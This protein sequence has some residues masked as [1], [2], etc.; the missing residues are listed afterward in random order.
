[1]KGAASRSPNCIKNTKK[2][3]MWTAGICSVAKIMR[4]TASPPKISL[5]SGNQ[6]LSYGQKNDFF[7]SV[8]RFEF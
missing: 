7:Q 2:Y 1:M 4:K 5:K 3:V 6:L 8:R